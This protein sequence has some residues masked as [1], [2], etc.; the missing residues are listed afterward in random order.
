MRDQILVKLRRKVRRLSEKATSEYTAIAGELPTETL[1]RVREAT[2]DDL[3]TWLKARPSIGQ[4][5][6]GLQ[7]RASAYRFR[8]PITRMSILRPSAGMVT[9]KSPTNPW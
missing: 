9:V 3:K 5:L 2:L 8:F 4:I 6:I 1:D 7:R